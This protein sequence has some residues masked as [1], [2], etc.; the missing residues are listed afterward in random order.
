M[1]KITESDI[2]AFAI[3]LL[4]KQGYRYLYG[5]AIAP[6]SDAPQRASFQDVLLI[7][8]LSAAV[9]R[10]NPGVPEPA[11]QDALRQLQRLVSTDLV[12]NNQ[13]FH[14]M[15]TE[16][17]TVTYQKNGQSRGDLVWL[18]DFHAPENND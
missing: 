6:D 2:E 4:E 8:A 9:A 12:A 17:I 5:P 1:T 14:R 10:I 3:E 13:A 11:R 16:G 7:D 18:V 15:L